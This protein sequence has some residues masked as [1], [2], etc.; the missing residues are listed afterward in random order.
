MRLTRY[1][2][3][4]LRV[5]I[6]LAARGDEPASIQDIAKAYGISYNHLMKVVNALA[7]HGFVET[8]RGRKGGIR[9]AHPAAKIGVGDVVR[10]TEDG[11]DLAECGSCVIAPA[12]GLT[13]VLAKGVNAML[14]VFDDYTIA[15]F[16]TKRRQLAA[17]LDAAA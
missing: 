1:T 11:M 2:D 4:S 12:C 16:M 5:L 13:P 8:T 10:K 15:D 7:H 3:Y 17:A 14:R 9:L 6:Y